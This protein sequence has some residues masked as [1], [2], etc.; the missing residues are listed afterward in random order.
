MGKKLVISLLGIFASVCVSH[1]SAATYN[2]SSIQTD[3]TYTFT[4]KASQ[5]TSF[6]DIFSFTLNTPTS[7]SLKVTE[8][9]QLDQGDYIYN[10]SDATFNYNIF[11]SSNQMVTNFNNLLAGNYT[12]KVSGITTGLVGG[13]YSVNIAT[14]VPEPETDALILIGVGLLGWAARKKSA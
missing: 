3:Q 5:Y 8:I 4:V 14:P 9:E 13:S 11:N 2:S 1:A 12:L 10:I 7:I 6:D